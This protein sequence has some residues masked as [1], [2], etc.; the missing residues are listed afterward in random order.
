MA[1]GKIS[2]AATETVQSS[3]Y[4]GG[5]LKTSHGIKYDYDDTTVGGVTD[6]LAKQADRKEKFGDWR[7]DFFKKGY[8]VVKWE[9]PRERAVQYRERA[10]DWFQK[11]DFGFD[12]NDKSKWTEDHL[13]VTMNAGM[14][15]GYCVT[16]EKWVWEARCEPGVIEP[17][18]QL[19]GTDEL[20]VSFDALKITLPGRKDTKWTPWPHVDRAPTPKGLACAQDI[21]NLSEAGPL[22]GGLQLLQGS[23]ELFEQFFKEHPPKPKADD[24]PGQ[25]D[26]YRFTLEDVKWFEDHGCNL[27]KVD[28][29]P[30]DVIIWDSRTVHYASLPQKDLKLKGE[31]FQRFEGT[32]HWPPCNI[33]AQ[34]KAMRGDKICPGE[35]S[36]PLEKPELTDQ[37]L[38]LA[39]VKPY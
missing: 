23:S 28:A 2:S 11:F 36:E 37:V 39:G 27:I 34:G 18:A 35:R 5:Y 1:S 17:F 21:I 8:I 9:I 32:T 12:I 26:W 30:G 38:K 31:I 16:H 3:T 6:I 22:D 10:M 13:P 29:E 33:F 20:L 7:N 24:A 19:W 14:I 4:N 25:F 15:M